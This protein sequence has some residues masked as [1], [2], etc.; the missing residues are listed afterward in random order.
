MEMLQQKENPIVKNADKVPFLYRFFKI[1]QVLS[2]LPKDLQYY[3][4]TFMPE[5]TFYPLI[6]LQPQRVLGGKGGQVYAVSYSSDGRYILT[7]GLKD[8]IVWN[9]KS[10]KL[11][12][13]I[14]C[15]EAEVD[16]AAIHSET[17]TLA[18][19][20]KDG[21]KLYELG[22]NQEK[23]IIY[24]G[25]CWDMHFSKDG[26]L[27]LFKQTFGSEIQGVLKY[28]P[29]K[30]KIELLNGV[31]FDRA[32][33]LMRDEKMK[34]PLHFGYSTI[35]GSET[36]IV[37][38]GARTMCY[39][40]A[41]Q[42]ID[43]LNSK[44]VSAVVSN[45]GKKVA[46]Y[47]LSG[48]FIYNLATKELI[49]C[50]YDNNPLVNCYTVRG[51]KAN[52]ANE[53]RI[54]FLIFNPDCS[55]II[56]GSHDNTARIW[57]ATTGKCLAVMPHDVRVSMGSFNHDGTQVCFNGGQDSSFYEYP[58]DFNGELGDYLKRRVTI[59]Q[60][61][62]LAFFNMLRRDQQQTK[63]IEIL[64]S[65]ECDELKVVFYSFKEKA[66]RNYLKLRY[67]LDWESQKPE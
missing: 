25:R 40:L 8:V 19:S 5:A 57:D 32:T 54:N 30:E 7:N 45:D 29:I 63:F 53:V 35:N 49:A 26:S 36:S 13:K 62:F 17:G 31:M 9:A 27:Y 50:N 42:T 1:D 28:D 52:P 60:L 34:Y 33:K 21:V 4:A 38:S 48:L 10:G 61:L 44:S 55:R 66:V 47:N 41:T 18:I 23:K 14:T 11:I 59:E 16:C 65:E 3:I 20:W 58:C 39:N 43:I 51:W 24:E 37:A 46:Y 12:Q 2:G 22:S 6:L 64:T 67:S 15:K 56:A